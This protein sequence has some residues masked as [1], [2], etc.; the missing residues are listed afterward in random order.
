MSVAVKGTKL[1]FTSNA[2][3]SV[4]GGVILSNASGLSVASSAYKLANG[5]LTEIK[6]RL[7]KDTSVATNYDIAI[8]GNKIVFT[9]KQTV[10]EFANVNSVVFRDAGDNPMN[11]AS[12]PKFGYT[13]DSDTTATL[14]TLRTLKSVDFDVKASTLT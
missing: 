13:L 4:E 14:A 9:A 8:D 7:L 5:S 11:P 6:N 1:E 3:F 2:E 10:G 12:T